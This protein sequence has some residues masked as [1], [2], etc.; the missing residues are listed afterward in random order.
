VLIELHR[1][2]AHPDESPWDGFARLFAYT[3][4]Q[5]GAFDPSLDRLVEYG[6]FWLD[7]SATGQPIHF[8]LDGL[9][10]VAPSFREACYDAMDELVNKLRGSKSKV[11]ITTRRHG[12]EAY[13]LGSLRVFDLQP[14][15]AEQIVQYM[16]KRLACDPEKALAI[17]LDLSERLRFQTSNPLHLNLLCEVLRQGE[18]APRSRA[19][20]FRL[21]I[22]GVLQRW[23]AAKH[24]NFGQRTFS[25]GS[26]HEALCA[27]AVTMQTSGR[28]LSQSET[29][30]AIANTQLGRTSPQKIFALLDELCTNHLMRRRHESVEFIHHAVQEYF[31][32]TA[33][34]ADW[35]SAHK[36]RENPNVSPLLAVAL[37]DQG[38]W[39]P[40]SMIGGLL[41][42]TE[43]TALLTEVSGH[44]ILASMIIANSVPGTPTEI[45][46][47]RR[48]KGRL[49]TGIS[50]T[51][52][53]SQA[54]LWGAALFAALMISVLLITGMLST[55]NIP[56]NLFVLLS[57]TPW[58]GLPPI[59]TFLISTVAAIVLCRTI[60]RTIIWGMIFLHDEF[61]RLR[62][63]T[64]IEPS[65]LALRYLESESA[66]GAIAECM[67]TVKS[68]R[69]MDAVIVERVG[70]Y[71]GRALPDDLW[72][73]SDLLDQP[74]M[75]N[76]AL[77]ILSHGY[78]LRFASYLLEHLADRSRIRQEA[79]ISLFLT[80]L[81]RYGR[82]R[83]EFAPLVEERVAA[84]DWPYPL[85]RRLY[86]ALRQAKLAKKK[87]HGGLRHKVTT[88]IGLF[89]SVANVVAGIARF[90]STIL[91]MRRRTRT[92]D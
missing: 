69:W 16:S 46:H 84:E 70:V 22:D 50:D 14:L 33:L 25:L 75:K 28:F 34:L 2:R 56:A 49:M 23:E 37:G 3:L 59:W 27:I 15:S 63:E 20:L 91:R 7:Q 40:L 43:L 6:R 30:R 10:E 44:P 73:L 17:Y 19:Q 67:D 65:L 66:K 36:H 79:E 82:A 83:D 62:M 64:R 52:L 71:A 90:S 4:R 85:R 51:I 48:L 39:E 13:L 87:P 88:G 60:Y 42:T 18:A 9:N 54:Y 29:E 61:L 47:V 1:Y 5:G 57:E 21:F 81:R 11:L 24:Y 72:E 77:A 45:E 32:A 58:D 38:W 68:S 86:R 8:Y 53:L 76:I 26:K 74:G 41:D 89:R 12:F 78:D 31:C 55:F 92:D 35:Q 80:W